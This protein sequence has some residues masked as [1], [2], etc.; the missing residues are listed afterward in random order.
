[1]FLETLPRV[2]ALA[3][4]LHVENIGGS[5]SDLG[6]QFEKDLEQDPQLKQDAQKEAEKE[7]Q[8]LEKDLKKDL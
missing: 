2:V 6:N 3:S 8:D 5:V 7:G 4:S 1:L